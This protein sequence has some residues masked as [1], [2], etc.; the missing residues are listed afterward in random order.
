MIFKLPSPFTWQD[1]TELPPGLAEKGSELSPLRSARTVVALSIARAAQELRILNFTSMSAA[2]SLLQLLVPVQWIARHAFSV[3]PSR[4]RRI[5][6]TG[7]LSVMGFSRGKDRIRADWRQ[8]DVRLRRQSARAR[9]DSGH[10][11]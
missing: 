3:V 8:V 11:R 7:F 6:Y 1:L 9:R 10:E 4:E 5:P 2:F